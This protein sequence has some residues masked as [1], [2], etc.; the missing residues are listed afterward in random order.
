VG[1]KRINDWYMEVE[2]PT[3]MVPQAGAVG[4][5]VRERSNHR[6]TL[7]RTEIGNTPNLAARKIL[8]AGD[9]W[10]WEISYGMNK[11]LYWRNKEENLGLFE[12]TARARAFIDGELVREVTRVV[13]ELQCF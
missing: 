6:I 10:P 2:L 1:V 3:L 8:L 7:F 13:R 11:D 5:H 4:T 12:E 9:E